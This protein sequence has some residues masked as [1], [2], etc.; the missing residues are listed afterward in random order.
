[1]LFIGIDV[2]LDGGVAVIDEANHLTVILS[3]V[4]ILQSGTKAKPKTK[5]EFDIDGMVKILDDIIKDCDSSELFCIIEKSQVMPKQGSVSGH[6]TGF[7][8]ALWVGM[9]HALRIPYK[10]LRP[11][12]WQR[13]KQCGLFLGHPTGKPKKTSRLVATNMFPDT[14]FRRTKTKRSKVAHDGLTDA[15]LIAEY[16]RRKHSGG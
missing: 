16:A 8:D 3:P 9:V 13:D 12:V 1:M 4:L 11:Q 6:R 7:G 5:R 15:A 2:G 10:H 14:D